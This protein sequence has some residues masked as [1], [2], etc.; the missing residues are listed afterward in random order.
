ME[1]NG[2]GRMGIG[3]L[4]SPL[5]WGLD[6]LGK[7]YERGGVGTRMVAYN[8]VVEISGDMHGDVGLS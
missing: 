3:C 2:S 6:A 5:I 7:S 8:T 1:W 4:L